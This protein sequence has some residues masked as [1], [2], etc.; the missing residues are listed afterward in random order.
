MRKASL[1]YPSAQLPLAPSSLM[2][3]LA[4][5][6]VALPDPAVSG[7]KGRRRITMSLREAIALPNLAAA[8][9]DE[10]AAGVCKLLNSAM[11]SKKLQARLGLIR[12]AAVDDP[13]VFHTMELDAGTCRGLT[14]VGV[15]DAMRR[16]EATLGDLLKVPGLGVKSF[17]GIVLHL[18]QR[19]LIA[20]IAAATVREATITTG[21]NAITADIR[22]ML[23]LR[24]GSVRD[25]EV[26]IALAGIETGEPANTR[27]AG[28]MF[29]LSHQRANVIRARVEQPASGKLFE[30]ASYPA[31]EGLVQHM[32][33]EHAGRL[34]DL[35]RRFEFQSPASLACIVDFLRRNVGLPG[36]R[37][38]EWGRETV[39]LALEDQAFVYSLALAAARA[40][41]AAGCTTFAEVLAEV[42]R[43]SP[44]S[45]DPK[46]VQ[47]AIEC[48]PGSAWLDE[49]HDRFIFG[50]VLERRLLRAVDQVTGAFGTVD[51][52]TLAGGLERDDKLTP[53]ARSPRLES[54]LQQLGYRVRAGRVRPRRLSVIE[55]GREKPVEL[56]ML[57]VLQRAGGPL[58]LGDFAQRCQRKNISRNVFYPKFASSPLFREIEGEGCLP[59]VA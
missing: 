47:L 42:H 23:T 36:L 33:R 45:I 46:L 16:G 38:T 39:Y 34:T 51:L 13:L 50:A 44:D 32:K 27:D 15:V 57:K 53:V 10:I 20:G 24:A 1:I 43:R 5:K 56:R 28:R 48:M 14:E 18:E 41:G 25:A 26:Y 19:G 29:G 4:E 58:P 11:R 30:L 35:A 52:D 6:K 2:P 59:L 40:R 54:I 17:I 9:R 21:G 31:L 49:E 55:G 7:A 37:L 8:A 22:R 3:I 12:V